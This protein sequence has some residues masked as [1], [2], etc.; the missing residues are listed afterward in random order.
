MAR[1]QDNEGGCVWCCDAGSV[2]RMVSSWPVNVVTAEAALSVVIAGASV[3]RVC[4]VMRDWRLPRPDQWPVARLRGM[5]TSEEIRDTSLTSLAP[6][7][8]S[9]RTDPGP[10]ERERGYYYILLL[11]AQYF[12]SGYSYSRAFSP[13]KDTCR[14]IYGPLRNMLHLVVH[15]PVINKS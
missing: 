5:I 8:T 4:M 11:F 9:T 14:L 13:V 2:S 12:Y 1:D 10:D 6:A 3:Y 15:F 7:A